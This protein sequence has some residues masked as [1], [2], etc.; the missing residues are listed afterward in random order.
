LGEGEESSRFRQAAEKY[1]FMIHPP[2]VSNPEQSEESLL[3]PLLPVF[4]ER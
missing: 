4:Q 2:L 1:K 3:P